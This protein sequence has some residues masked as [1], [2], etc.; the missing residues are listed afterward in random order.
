MFENNPIG[1]IQQDHNAKDI[2]KTSE[3]FAYMSLGMPLC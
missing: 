1:N 2:E 3:N